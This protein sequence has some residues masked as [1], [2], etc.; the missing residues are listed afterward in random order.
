LK[1]TRSL[2]TN[3]RR[4]AWV[5]INL[6][7]LE[8]NTRCLKQA[9]SRVLPSSVELMAVVKA[10]AYGH[11]AVMVT[12]TLEAAGVT[13]LG[14]ASIDEAFQLRQA[15]I[16]LPVLVLGVVPDWAMPLA[17]EQDIQLTVFLEHQIQAIRDSFEK[18]RLPVKVHIKVD[19]GLHRIGVAWQKAADFITLCQKEKALQVEGVFSHLAKS[20]DGVECLKQ[21]QRFNA[22][23][24]QLDFIPRYVHLAN[25]SGVFHLD[26]VSDTVNQKADSRIAYTMVRLGISLFG[27]GDEVSTLKPVMGLKARIVHLQTVPPGEGVSYGHTFTTERPTIIATLPIG[28]ADGVPRGLSNNLHG[29]LRGHMVPQ[30]GLITMDQ[31]MVEVTD[32]PDAAIGDTVTLIGRKSETGSE[33]QLE[34]GPELTLTNWAK[35]LNTIEYELMCGLRVRLPRTYIRE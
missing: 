33:A 21:Q 1:L 32:V 27:Y 5:T 12:P 34:S 10:D 16:T 28:Y 3:T 4:D 31:L 15:G 17:V 7:A 22:V 14:V 26:H 2:T 29:F 25:S 30:R 18:T 24:S 23:L 11:G 9:I 19:T 35:H 6:N 8:Q 20:T 13:Y